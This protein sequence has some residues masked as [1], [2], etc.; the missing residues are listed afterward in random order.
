MLWLRESGYENATRFFIGTTIG[1]LVVLVISH[2]TTPVSADSGS[3][4]T[5]NGSVTTTVSSDQPATTLPD[6]TDVSGLIPDVKQIYYK[7]LGNPYRQVESEIT[8]PD[9]AAYFHKLMDDTGLDKVGLDRWEFI[10][11]DV[12]AIDFYFLPEAKESWKNHSH[13]I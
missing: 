9:I 3:A 10:H 8:D 13:L 6:G 1:L 5:S 4:T 12:S 11:G 7:A 2:N